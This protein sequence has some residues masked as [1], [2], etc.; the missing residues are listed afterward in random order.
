MPKLYDWYTQKQ[1]V[2]RGRFAP[3]RPP[4][5]A[6]IGPHGGMRTSGNGPASMGVHGGGGGVGRGVVDPMPQRRA[7]PEIQ[8][9]THIN[10]ARQ[11]CLLSSCGSSS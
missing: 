4:G 1:S 5:P 2:Q 3:I 10:G 6:S 11:V 9:N 8:P 7:V